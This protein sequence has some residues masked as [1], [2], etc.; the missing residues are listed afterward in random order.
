MAFQGSKLNPKQFE[1]SQLKFYFILIP[2]A[3]LMV[4]PIVYIVNQAFK[5]L[6]ELFM[7]PPRFLVVNPTWKNFQDLFETASE[8][9][10]PMTRY[11]FNS[12]IVTV[13]TVILTIYIT[14]TSAYAL[15]KKNFKAKKMMLSI[16]EAAL[17]FV[18]IAVMIPRYLMIVQVNLTNN[19]LAHIIPAL[20]MPVG[21][22]LVKQFIDQLPNELIEAARL[23]GASEFKIITSIVVPLIK[24]A[25]ATVGL[26]AFQSVWNATESSNLYITD[27]TVKTFAFYMN[28]LTS[29]ASGNTTAGAGMAAAA[30]LIMFLPNFIIFIFMQSRVMNTMSHSGIK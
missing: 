20:A 15:S 10:V 2:V 6:D 23:D 18:P 22:F 16:N 26:L 17:M 5:P 29:Q 14:A 28:T 3:F 12:I 24:P 13:V 8:T 30:S 27:E 19:L 4:L 11:L 9:G 21:I 25:L 7:F 1:R